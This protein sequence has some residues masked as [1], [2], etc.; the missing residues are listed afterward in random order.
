MTLQQQN[1]T[2]LKPVQ[3]PIK[4]G[5]G[6]VLPV[7]KGKSTKEIIAEIRRISKKDIFVI[8]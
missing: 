3:F 2:R 1:L 6:K 4:E 5:T 7:K 8:E